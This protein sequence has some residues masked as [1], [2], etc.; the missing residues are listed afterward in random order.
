MSA[1]PRSI[2]P[3]DVIAALTVC[4]GAVPAGAFAEVGVYE[5]GTAWHLLQICRRQ[6]RALHLFDT[7]TGLP[8][9]DAIDR[10][11]VGEFAGNEAAVRAALPDAVFHV[12]VFPDTLPA[13]TGPLA[14]VHVDCDQHRSVAACIDRLWPLLVPGGVM[15]FDDYGA[16]EGAR[17]AVD[18]CFPAEKL[19]HAPEGRRFVRKPDAPQPERQAMPVNPNR[20]VGF[21]SRKLYAARAAEGF[22]DRFV[23]G[24]AVLDIGFRGG[25]GDALPIVDGAVGVE[26]GTPGYDGLRLP[27]PDQ[28]QDAVHASHVLEHVPDA[29]A[30]LREWFR[31]L[32]VGGHL[33]L[34]VPHAC[35]Y[36]RR[37]SVPPSRWSPEHVRSFTPASLLGL[38]ERVLPPNHYRVRRLADRDDGYEYGLPA[39]AH[40][41]GALEIECVLQRIAPPAWQVEP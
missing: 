20:P 36:E 38:V 18:A 32:R 28:S 14:F 26:L 35:L 30:S 19:L 27:W 22:W 16:L 25:I 21:E 4:A 15:W 9:A 5:G 33:L 6:G 23:T 8:V 2:V 40:P 12:G 1:P 13:D 34:F 10:H 29:E 11:G 41:T 31:V 17:V 37:L 3:A 39:S 7:F 24:P